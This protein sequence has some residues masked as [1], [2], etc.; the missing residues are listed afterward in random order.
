M[1][2][3]IIESSTGYVVAEMD[4]RAGSDWY[5]QNPRKVAAQHLPHNPGCYARITR[6]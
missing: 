6:A 1:R 3:L 2:L 4:F 5:G